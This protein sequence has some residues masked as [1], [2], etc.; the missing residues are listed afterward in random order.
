[1]CVR[2]RCTVHTFFHSYWGARTWFGLVCVCA[3]HLL[4]PKWHV[5]GNDGKINHTCHLCKLTYEYEDINE[6]LFSCHVEQFHS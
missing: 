3:C 5:I 1:M 6:F 4:S 2:V